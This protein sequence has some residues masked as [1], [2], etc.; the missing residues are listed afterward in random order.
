MVGL[1]AGWSSR[2]L[3]IVLGTWSVVDTIM[4]IF[5]TIVSSRTGDRN[6]LVRLVVST[7]QI[8][9][10]WGSAQARVPVD[11]PS[12]WRQSVGR[13]SQITIDVSDSPA[14]ICLPSGVKESPWIRGHGDS[15]VWI[16]CLSR[17]R[18]MRMIPRAG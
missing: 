14:T 15:I 7:T 8:V 13:T 18:K 12:T 6:P 17:S 5:A 2:G 3:M 1:P 16:S 10:V 4:V 9:S 11:P